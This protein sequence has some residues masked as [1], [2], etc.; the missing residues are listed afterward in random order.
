MGRR[1]RSDGVNDGEQDRGIWF[2]FVDLI[3]QR[4]PGDLPR[5]RIVM[6]GVRVVC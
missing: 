3:R 1:L 2:P 6:L 5:H 4:L